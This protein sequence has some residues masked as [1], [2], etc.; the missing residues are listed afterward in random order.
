MAEKEDG[1]LQRELG[2]SR[3]DLLR[4]GAV[5]GGTLLWATPVIQS[6][7][8]RALADHNPYDSC[9]ECFFESTNR[10]SCLTDHNTREECEA[11][12]KAQNGVVTFYG[13]GNFN[14]NDDNPE[15]EECVRQG[16]EPRQ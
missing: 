7:G 8:S 9:C 1:V 16:P 10:Q 13:E 14:C 2:I 11:A 6:V 4:R 5:V 15:F 12:C 3:R